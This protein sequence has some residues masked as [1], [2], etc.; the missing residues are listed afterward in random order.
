[1]NSL[2][3]NTVSTITEHKV[4]VVRNLVSK[5]NTTGEKNIASPIPLEIPDKVAEENTETY[6][7]S[8][9]LPKRQPPQVLTKPVPENSEEKPTIEPTDQQ[10]P[11]KEQEQKPE[12]EPQEEHQEEHQEQTEEEISSPIQEIG[13]P[14]EEQESPETD[15]VQDSQETTR[16]QKEKM[17]IQRNGS[18][19]ILSTS[20][21]STFIKRTV[22]APSHS[23]SVL[24]PPSFP[25][26]NPFPRPTATTNSMLTQRGTGEP[27]V[28]NTQ[29]QARKN[30]P[31]QM[32][33]QRRQSTQ[34]Q[35]QQPQ[36]IISKPSQIMRSQAYQRQTQQP[37]VPPQAGPSNAPR[38]AAQKIQISSMETSRVDN[39]SKQRVFP[40]KVKRQT[41]ENEDT[42][43]PQV[44]DFRKRLLQKMKQDPEFEKKIRELHAKEFEKHVKNGGRGPLRIPLKL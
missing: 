17:V 35:K 39:T 26:R 3:R 14:V 30:M 15:H 7:S 43:S 13:S 33:P 5:R 44:A 16:N 9:F 29:E 37:N 4:S 25:Q 8:S 1:M 23:S 42:V 2:R 6:R 27:A 12:K 40:W 19:K 36:L 20:A 10:S 28:P 24:P 11:S 38:T 34:I 31:R 18:K 32:V 22:L 41:Q 21:F